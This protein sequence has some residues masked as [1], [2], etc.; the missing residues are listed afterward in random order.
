MLPDRI[1]IKLQNNFTFDLIKVEGGIFWMGDDNGQYDYE[2]PAHQV[3]LDTFYLGE[4]PVT[5]GLWKAVMGSEN[6]PSFFKGDNR[7]V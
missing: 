4:F 5:Q 1:S 6:N 7:P 3:D 2:K